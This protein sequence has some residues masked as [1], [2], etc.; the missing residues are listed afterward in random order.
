MKEILINQ[1][2]ENIPRELQDCPQWILFQKVPRTNRYGEIK[3]AKIPTSPLTLSS[4]DWNS[5]KM[6]T[7]FEVAL[8]VLVNSK[9]D[10]LAFVLSSGDPFVCIDLDHCIENDSLS[11]PAK[12]I[13]ETF[14][15]SYMELSQSKQ[16][17]H[18]FCKGQVPGNLNSQVNGVE[19]Y[20]GNHCI[21]M[22]G[23]VD[24]KHLKGSE[25]LI[26]Y[27]KE[28]NQ[29]YQD[30][31]PRIQTR[32]FSEAPT[33]TEELPDS[34]TIIDTMCRF[35]QRARELFYGSN[36]SGDWSKDDF[37][38]LLLLRSFTHGNSELMESI[39]LQSA[40]SRLGENSKRRN[41]E[42][43]LKYLRGSIQKANQ[44]GHQNFWD[45]QFIKSPRRE[46]SR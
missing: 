29:L 19:I 46:L 45:Y 38:L 26:D 18:I 41:E 17:I 10:G 23:D 37:S 5:K 36:L 1:Y 32:A 3:F 15:G 28:L 40:L 12:A 8:Y 31:T 35:N 25:T 7:S 11:L 39:F 4:T 13:V 30:Y 16:G 2:K 44:I 33:S 27:D 22:T 14:T 42:S 9:A 24:S 6:W 21:A 20:Q 43:Y 34:S